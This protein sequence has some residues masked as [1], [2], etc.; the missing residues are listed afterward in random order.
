VDA[1]A[2]AHWSEVSVPL[3]RLQSG[4]SILIPS[5]YPGLWN[6]WRAVPADRG[7]KGDRV[8][9]A[10]VERLELDIEARHA[11]DAGIDAAGVDVESIWLSFDGQ[12]EPSLR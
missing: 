8:H 9:V 11:G 7:G 4:R 6:Y 5:P 2:D 10:D 3:D 1:Q 12:S